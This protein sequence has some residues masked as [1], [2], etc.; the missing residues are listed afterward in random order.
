VNRPALPS[1]ESSQQMPD[2]LRH[3]RQLKIIPV[4]ALVS[5]WLDRG[6]QPSAASPYRAVL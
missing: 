4:A 1:V 5:L 3:P 2:S 6:K